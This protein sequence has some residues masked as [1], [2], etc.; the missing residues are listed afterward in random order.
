MILIC[1]VIVGILSKMNNNTVIQSNNVNYKDFADGILKQTD[2][3]FKEKEE[4]TIDKIIADMKIVPDKNIFDAKIS[5]SKNLVSQKLN[6]LKPPEP[7]KDLFDIGDM[8]GKKPTPESESG[9]KINNP[10]QNILPGISDVLP[11]NIKDQIEPIITLLEGKYNEL[12]KQEGFEDIIKEISDIHDI[13]SVRTVIT[14]NKEKVNEIMNNVFKDEYEIFTGYTQIY[15]TFPYL[16][17]EFLPEAQILATIGTIILDADKTKASTWRA[18]QNVPI[19]ISNLEKLNK[20]MNS[21]R[22]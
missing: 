3:Q 2:K 5:E 15:N 10:V 13:N 20:K 12:K 19:V 22:I 21:L 14:N 6:D 9:S 1:V 7:K 11:S 4:Q 18:I 17:V 8:F 16:F